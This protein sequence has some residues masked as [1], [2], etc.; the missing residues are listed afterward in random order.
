MTMQEKEQEIIEDFNELR[1]EILIF[2]YMFCLAAETEW[3]PDEEQTDEKKVPGCQSGVWLDVSCKNGILNIK[4]TSDS[5]VVKGILA[6]L[7]KII[8]GEPCEQ[9]ANYKFDIIDKTFLKDYLS[10]ERV[11]GL[12]SVMDRIRNVI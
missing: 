1:D 5:L 12:R 4:C 10:E 11:L 6:I 8:N 9:V 2:E 3:M 7:L